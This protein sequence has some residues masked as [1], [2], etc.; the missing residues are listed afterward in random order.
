MAEEVITDDIAPADV[1]RAVHHDRHQREFMTRLLAPSLNLTELGDVM[2]AGIKVECFTEVAKD[3]LEWFLD[4]YRKTRSIPTKQQMLTQ[5]PRLEDFCLLQREDADQ[6][7]QGATTLVGYHR[8]V[9]DAFFL[10]T[11]QSHFQTL[12]DL[13]YGSKSVDDMWAHITEDI[14]ELARIRNISDQNAK[15]L[16]QAIDDVQEEFLMSKEGLT[17]G[18]P[19]PFPFLNKVLRGI[20]PGQLITVVAPP[21]TGKT[22]WLIM[23]AACAITGNPWLCTPPEKKGVTLTPEDIERYK[24]N[25]KRVL[26]VSKEMPVLDVARRT[27][28]I[29]TKFKYPEILNG[30]FTVESDE[31]AFLAAI[32]ALKTGEKVGDNL[33]IITAETA[34]QIAACADQFRADLVIVD[35]FYLMAGEG[36]KRWEHVQNNL[37]SFR[38]T[39]LA[40]NR[41]YILASQ[42][43]QKGDK[44]AFSQSVEQDSSIIIHLHQSL[45]EKNMKQLRMQTRKVREGASDLQY[46]YNW[47]IVNMRFSEEGAFVQTYDREDT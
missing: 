31:P 47:D 12:S 15:T 16:A 13:W 20:Q 28:A 4:Y 3:P 41:T 39:S 27:V 19:L 10:K 42:L 8:A 23:A 33:L 5:Y 30:K 1:E 46:Y 24:L 45:Q 34:D 25:A 22:W 14:R 36:E 35:G 6:V 26:F 38:D 44:L 37:K 11:L 40:T 32:Q 29:L 7:T 18:I 21:G 9:A 2:R 17:W 43:Q